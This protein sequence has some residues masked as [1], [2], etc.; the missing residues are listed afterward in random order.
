MPNQQGE[1]TQRKPTSAANRKNEER[2][3]IFK[4]LGWAQNQRKKYEREVAGKEK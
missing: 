4:P 2:K 3:D 1:C